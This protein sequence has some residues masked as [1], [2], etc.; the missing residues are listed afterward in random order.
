MSGREKR[1]GGQRTR[2][3]KKGVKQAEVKGR[4][5]GRGKTM[6]KEERWGWKRKEKRVKK[7]R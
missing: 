5:V 1:A 4:S 7:R 3:K 2:D 6:W